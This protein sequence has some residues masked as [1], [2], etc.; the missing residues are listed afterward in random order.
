MKYETD[1]NITIEIN[2]RRLTPESYGHGRQ[3]D[4]EI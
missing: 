3:Q 1:S 4:N 2:R